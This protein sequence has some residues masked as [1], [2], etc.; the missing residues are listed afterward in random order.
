MGSRATPN[1]IHAR[2]SLRDVRNYGITPAG[3]FV[4]LVDPREPGVSGTSAAP[5]IHVVL[6]WHEELKQRVPTK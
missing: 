2:N 5:E 1:G 6:N 3:T 4:A